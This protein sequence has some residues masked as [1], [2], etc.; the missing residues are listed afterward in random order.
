MRRMFLAGPFKSLV[1][2]RSGIMSDESIT[3]FSRI[4]IFFENIGWNVHSAHRRENWGK[5]FMTPDACTKK[6]YEEISRCDCFVAF[7]GSPVSPGT[8]IELGWA[9]ALGKP[10][11]MLLETQKTYAYLVQ[12]LNQI[13]RVEY[14][15]YENN[16]INPEII[17]QAIKR[18]EKRG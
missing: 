4:I 1:N 3:L 16:S 11:I 6:D 8:H 13:T 12:G 14:I 7:P 2:S 15:E 17:E 5:D 18:L 9:S 10:I